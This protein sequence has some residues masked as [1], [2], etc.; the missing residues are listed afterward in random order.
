MLAWPLDARNLDW[1]PALFARQPWRALTAALVHWS[2]LHLQANLLG[3][4]VLGWL[5]WRAELPARATAAWALAWPLTQLTLLL[6]PELK[7]YGGLSG[8]LHAG[9]IIVAAELL[10]R[11]GRERFI[12]AALSLGIGAKLLLEQPLGAPLH[13][14]AGWDIAIAPVAHL[15]GVVAGLLA[16]LMLRQI[17]SGL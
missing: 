9:A 1:Q 4:A 8:V 10:T 5:G 15:G 16:W 3:C 12:G 2:A 11:P 17:R 6:T 14:V 13:T 7:S